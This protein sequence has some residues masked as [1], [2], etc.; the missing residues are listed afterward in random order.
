LELRVDHVLRILAVEDNADHA[1]I[2]KFHLG[3]LPDL[4]FEFEHAP[5]ADNARR[6]LQQ[7]HFNL[8]FLDYQLHGQTGMDVL[9]D[10]RLRGVD[11]P[12][13][14]VTSQGDEYVAVD[15]M[16]SGADDYIIKQDLGPEML[17]RTLKRLEQRL[18]QTQ[19]GRATPA[20]FDRA[21]LTPR[22]REILA[23][24]VAGKTNRAIAA[25]I[26]RSEKTV[27]IH[28]SNLMRKMGA[29]NTAELV[30]IAMS[31]RLIDG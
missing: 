15:M 11:C 6:L 9:H 18:R 3:R 1:A 13:V 10:L 21:Q 25:D 5:D 24:I 8:I 2:L 29:A 31:Q 23:H 7:Q 20:L 4:Q 27:K 14:V 26:F 17:A 19:N 16:R 22:E 30:R 28:R 12:V